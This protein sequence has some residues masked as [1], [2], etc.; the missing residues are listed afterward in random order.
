MHTMNSSTTVPTAIRMDAHRRARAS[1][2]RGPRA[3]IR[4]GTRSRS[5]TGFVRARALYQY[6]SRNLSKQK[7]PRWVVRSVMARD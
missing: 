2:A 5:A 6:G 7:G 1:A 3:A 4:F